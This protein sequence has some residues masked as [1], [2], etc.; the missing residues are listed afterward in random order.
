MNEVGIRRLTGVLRRRKVAVIAA[1]VGVLG[2]AVSTILI[3]EP[4]YKA[5]AIWV[6]WADCCC[7]NSRRSSMRTRA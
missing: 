1:F 5:S 3:M 7:P 4:S 6:R 2:V